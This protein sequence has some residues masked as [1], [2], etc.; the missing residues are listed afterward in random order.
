MKTT[1]SVETETVSENATLVTQQLHC[2]ECC[3]PWLDPHERWRVYLT[4]DEPAE[5]VPY[6]ADCARREFDA[7]PEPSARPVAR[8]RPI[9][10]K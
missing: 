8:P 9:P 4:D 5:A 2:Q 3:R 10:D 1:V 7:D 6:C